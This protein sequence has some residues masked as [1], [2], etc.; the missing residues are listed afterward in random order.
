MYT[1]MSEGIVI[2]FAMTDIY[3]EYRESK[4]GTNKTLK[5][6]EVLEKVCDMGRSIVQLLNPCSMR[7]LRVVAWIIRRPQRESNLMLDS[8]YRR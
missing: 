4:K 1:H 2:Y 6:N 7:S 5:I 8:Y 3:E